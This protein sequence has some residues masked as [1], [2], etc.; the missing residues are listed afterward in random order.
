[1]LMISSSVL[2]FIDFRIVDIYPASFAGRHIACQHQT[3]G[4]AAFLRGA[5]DIAAGEELLNDGFSEETIEDDD[6]DDDYEMEGE[7][8]DFGFDDDYKSE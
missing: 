2:Y 4:V 6:E 8:S 1:M 7:P 5:D 3:K